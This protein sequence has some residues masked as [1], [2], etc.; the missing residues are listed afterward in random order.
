MEKP[1]LDI[2]ISIQ[3]LRDFYWYKEELLAFCRY[4]N[5]DKRG[6]KIDIA[7]RIETYLKT[8]AKEKYT[9]QVSKSTSRFDWNTEK[10]TRATI[11]SDNYK[12]TENVRLFFKEQIGATFKF[13][14]KFMNWMKTAQGQHLGSA[15]AMWKKINEDLRQNNSRKEIAPQFEYNTYMRDFLLDN[16]KL[17]RTIAIKCWNIKKLTRGSNKYSKTDLQNI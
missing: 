6:G 3:D 13:N 10:L 11:I 15:I 9:K 4:E 17:S 8:S 2:H 16:P 12:N 14:V 1:K 7:N 5:L